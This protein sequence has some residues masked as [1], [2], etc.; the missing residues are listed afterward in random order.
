M[1]NFLYTRVST[2][3]QGPESLSVQNQVCLN[4]LNSEG[5]TLNGSFQE[6]GSAYKGN[7]KILN[8]ILN[9]YSNCKV[10]VLNVSRFSRNILIGMDMLKK[11]EERNI[12][13]HFIEEGLLSNN[14]HHHHQIRM[15]LLEF[16]NESETI[17]NR[18]LN[19]NKVRVKSGWK[20]GVA[21]F[22]KKSEIINGVRKFRINDSERKITDFIIQAREGIS[23]KSLNSKLKKIIPNAV[24]INFYDTDGVTLIKYFEK[25]NSLSFSEIADL[26]NDYNI[27]KRGKL[28]T[29]SKVSVVYDKATQ[30]PGKMGELSIKV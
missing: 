19:L 24:P 8:N 29:A 11:A 7:Q 13:I 6:I 14:K 26:L 22:G 15:K 3:D 5:L 30:M 28:W 18:Q 27:C 12:T 16:Q 10:F 23:S 9:K 21:K 2:N 1:Q 25:P 17:S 4:Y 20:F